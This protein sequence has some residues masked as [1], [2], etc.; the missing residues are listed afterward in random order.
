MKSINLHWEWI[1]TAEKIEMEYTNGRKKYRGSSGSCKV[2]SS[3]AFQG[4][5][6]NI[7]QWGTHSL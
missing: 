7:G 1:P 4:N 6:V 5:E 3:S 2:H